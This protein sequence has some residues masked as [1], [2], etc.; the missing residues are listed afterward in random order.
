[1]AFP[2]LED[3]NRRL[4]LPMPLP[5]NWTSQIGRSDPPYRYF[6][7]TAHLRQSVSGNCLKYTSA[8]GMSRIGRRVF[9]RM[10]GEG[11]RIALSVPE[12][13]FVFARR[14]PVY[15]LGVP[16]VLQNRPSRCRK[17]GFSLGGAKSPRHARAYVRSVKGSCRAG[18][19]PCGRIDGHSPRSRIVGTQTR[20]V[21]HARRRIFRINS[22]IIPRLRHLILGSLLAPA[23]GD[24]LRHRGP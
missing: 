19:Q 20:P 22:R 12:T 13:R 2:C 15:G 3:G 18:L 5:A 6:G 7:R 9:S 14:R 4:D 8:V 10:G 17:W 11:V 1:M 23:D 21:H 16:E 24:T